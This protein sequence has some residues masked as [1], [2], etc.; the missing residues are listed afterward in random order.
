MP[1]QTEQPQ[2][3][4]DSS[5][6]DVELTD[7][8][9]WPADED[10]PADDDASLPPV[11]SVVD[12]GI[13]DTPIG[14]KVCPSATRKGNPCKNI[15]LDGFA[16]CGHHLDK[17]EREQ[18]VE[19]ADL[20]RPR[21]ILGFNS[22]LD[23]Y[24]I[25]LRLNLRGASVE[26]TSPENPEWSPINDPIMDRHHAAAEIG[27]Y[28]KTNEGKMV[29][30][31]LSQVD[32]HKYI[33]AAAYENRCDPFLDWLNDLP[34]WDGVD[35]VD[36]M[37]FKL[38]PSAAPYDLALWVSRFLVL[39]AV[40]RAHRPGDNMKAMPVLIGPQDC[41]KSTLIEHLAIKPEWFTSAVCFEDTAKANDERTKGVVFAEFAE[42]A[43]GTR[44]KQDKQKAYISATVDGQSRG[45]Y[46]RNKNVTPRRWVPVAT[47]NDV[48]AGTLPNDSSGHVRYVC[49]E[50][51]AAVTFAYEWPDTY[52]E[53]LYAEALH[54]F[55]AGVDGWTNAR[56]PAGLRALRDET[57]VRHVKADVYLSEKLAAT[58]R[59]L[60]RKHPERARNAAST[61]KGF[62]AS[63][64]IDAL[65]ESDAY[66]E[67]IQLPSGPQVA[68]ELRA[69]YW[70]ASNKKT[71]PAPGASPSLSW[72]PPADLIEDALEGQQPQQATL[73]EDEARGDR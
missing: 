27:Y 34:A 69:Q 36:E 9:C 14:S 13:A 18:R 51:G 73:D 42:F 6:D 43:G 44:A 26:V 3:K 16:H 57:N 47:A 68:N 49:I 12:G 40:I 64:M 60:I 55:K 19:Q 45:A 22:I 37:I 56:L 4:Q 46:A 25:D 2:E 33:N 54:K 31:K 39:A 59:K 63:E 29:A 53:Q 58:V 41:G 35:R 32:W 62:F 21:N 61:Q 72:I 23:E 48:G 30:W 8:V 28:A 71:R 11:L 50:T 65:G 52:V 66:S 70:K 1:K 24:G 67:R 7:E 15:I 10:E 38:W 17:S 20:I 5:L